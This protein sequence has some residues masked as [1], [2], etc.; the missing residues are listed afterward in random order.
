[1]ATILEK[2][3]LPVDNM[4]Y[5]CRLNAPKAEGKQ[6]V[7]MTKRYLALYKQTPVAF[8]LKN[9]RKGQPTRN[10]SGRREMF[11]ATVP[12]KNV[13]DNSQRSSLEI[14]SGRAGE[15]HCR[16]VIRAS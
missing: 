6:I 9:K 15:K 12:G 16:F 14:F 2:H 5:K 3:L 7:G 13:L 1:M 4:I 10:P 8:P 11:S